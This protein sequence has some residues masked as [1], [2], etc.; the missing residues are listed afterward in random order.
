M[1]LALKQKLL[2][3]LNQYFSIRKRLFEEG[4]GG[5]LAT[6]STLSGS[7]PVVGTIQNPAGLAGSLY[8]KGMITRSVRD[9][10]QQRGDLITTRKNEVLINAVE[11]QVTM[12]PSMFQ[13]FMGVLKEEPSLSTIVERM[14]VSSK[15]AS[16]SVLPV[17]MA[18]SCVSL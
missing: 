5:W 17:S 12:D 13:A 15:C 4:G 3:V 10:I 14:S 7:A 11:A 2:I 8:S 16:L 1:L 18:V 6:L 9:E